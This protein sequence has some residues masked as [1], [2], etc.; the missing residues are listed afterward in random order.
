MT[1]DEKMDILSMDF[2]QMWYRIW[3]VNPESPYTPDHLKLT[4]ERYEKYLICKNNFYKNFMGDSGKKLKALIAKSYNVGSLWEIP[5]GRRC[6]PQEKELNCALREFEEETN[7]K[8]SEFHILN[9]ETFT[10]VVTSMQVKYISEYFIALM[11]EP[12]K[13]SDSPKFKYPKL[14]YENHHQISEVADMVWMDIDK[15]KMIDVNKPLLP[16]A[17]SINKTLRKKYKIKKY[18]SIFS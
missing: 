12:F 16:I 18:F 15:I 4:K 10:T 14:N 7:I 1:H 5:K 8:Q 6:S 13:H 2:G 17:K 9:E 11:N 3:F